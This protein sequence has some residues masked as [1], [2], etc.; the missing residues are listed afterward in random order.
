MVT[1]ST[2]FNISKS[3]SNQGCYSEEYQIYNS[4]VQLPNNT[5]IMP[6]VASEKIPHIIVYHWHSS[7]DH[8]LYMLD[9]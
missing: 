3:L 4:K 6:R 5:E 7:I 8:L 1:S 2:A 9:A